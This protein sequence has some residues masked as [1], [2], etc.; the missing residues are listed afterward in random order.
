MLQAMVKALAEMYPH[1][2]VC[3]HQDHGNNE[4]TCMTAI[5]YGFTSVMMDGSLQA[6][7]KTPASYTYNTDIT[8]RVTEMAHHAGVSVE[9]ELGVL[10]SLE[11]GRVSKKMA[12]V[13]PA[14]YRRPA[15][16]RPGS[17]RGFCQ[18][19]QG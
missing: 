4:A 12:M 1:I 14:N 17:G 15:F 5:Q 18:T 3:M 10:G 6:D 19:D 13:P 11:T 9:G 16:D 2:P 7:A 8:E